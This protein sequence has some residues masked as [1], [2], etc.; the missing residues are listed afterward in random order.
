MR[1]SRR[2][3]TQ[4][5][6]GT[7]KSNVSVV[8]NNLINLKEFRQ[9]QLLRANQE[10]ALDHANA[11]AKQAETSRKHVE[12][13]QLEALEALNASNI[14]QK[15]E[16]AALQK[17][18]RDLLAENARLH[19][20][21]TPLPP[22]RPASS[23]ARGRPSTAS[24]IPVPKRKQAR[25]SSL[26][27]EINTRRLEDDLR[28]TRATLASTES[29]LQ[30]A[31]SKLNRT[32]DGLLKAENVKFALEKRFAAEHAELQSALEE[33]KDELRFSR[34]TV[35]TGFSREEYE[36]ALK[37]EDAIRSEMAAIEERNRELERK[38]QR[39]TD[40]LASAQEQLDQLQ[41]QD[42]PVLPFSEDVEEALEEA[43]NETARVTGELVLLKA[44]VKVRPF[45]LFLP[46]SIYMVLICFLSLGHHRLPRVTRTDTPNPERQRSRS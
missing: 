38:L 27:S 24:S 31:E 39:K 28:A 6:R 17:Q 43:R 41:F 4:T 42:P 35:D 37:A 18:V 19:S 10:T 5:N 15:D 45:P 34:Q 3:T 22:L 16:R 20:N 29:A 25:A 21:Q 44:N 12:Q 26:T 36:R 33:A 1:P 2:A 23:M 11:R 9:E 30:A 32:T 40:Q 8:S 13:Q 46:F 14:Q 7:N